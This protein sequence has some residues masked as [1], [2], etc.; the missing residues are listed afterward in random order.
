[1]LALLLLVSVTTPTIKAGGGGS[2]PPPGPVIVD[3]VAINEGSGV[4]TFEGQ[5]MDPSGPGTCTVYFGGLPSLAGESVKCDGNGYFS[6]SIPL[7]SADDGTATAQAVDG[8]GLKSAVADANV[9][10]PS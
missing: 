9:T 1:M 3:F 6:L 2:P 10:N 4:W 5:V 7:T 8:Q